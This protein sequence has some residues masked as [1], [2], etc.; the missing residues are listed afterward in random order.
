MIS[1]KTIAQIFETAK[2]E[3]VVGDFVNLKRRGVNM[4]GLC[5]FHDEKTPSFTVSPAKNICKCFGCGKGGSPV[6]FLMEHDNL[7]YPEA[8]RVLAKKYGIE[9][10]ED[11]NPDKSK[12]E[13]QHLESLYLINQFTKDFFIDQMN[14]TDIGRS[15]GLHYFKDR[16]FREDIIERFGLGYSPNDGKSLMKKLDDVGYE[17]TLYEKLGVVKNGRDFFRGRVMF[18]IHNLTGKCIGFGGRILKANKKAPK[19]VNS[20]EAEIYNKSKILYGMFFAKNAIRKKDECILVEGYTDT[21]SL[22]QAGIENV[23]ASSGTSLTIEQI[24]LIKRFTP[25]IK[26][27]YDGDAAGVKAALRGLDL[28]LE[29]DLNVKVVLLPE[30]EDPDSYAQA[31][32]TEAFV[33]YL[34]EKATDFILFKMNLLMEEAKGDPVKR[35]DLIK[36]IVSSISKIP[37]PIKRSVYVRE[38]AL[39][40][41]VGEKVLINAVNKNVVGNIQSRQRQQ[42]INERRAN[43]NAFE[44]AGFPEEDHSGNNDDEFGLPDSKSDNK[45]FESIG[46]QEKD[47]ARILINFGH[48]NFNDD[49]TIAQFIFT[50]IGEIMDAFKT[51]P[52]NSIVF[53]YLE[54]VKNK[55]SLSPQH[56]LNHSDQKIREVALNFNSSPYEYSPGWKERFNITTSQPEP[57]QNFISDTTQ[58]LMRFKLEKIKELCEENLERIK[59]IAGEKD[60]AKENRYMQVHIRLKKMEKELTDQLNTV[61]LKQ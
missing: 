29:Q 9:I 52:Y 26:I 20:S 39:Q 58:A 35:S 56:F 28:V 3:D 31:I 50:N 46:F 6:S 4:I 30:G 19:Y 57:D 48:Q 22:H 18:P 45:E 41:D 37:D 55:T 13:R 17:K 59:S 49:K 32:G 5:P 38:C 2:I 42:E 43:R 23:V 53:E 47:I 11:G 61:V 54:A 21:I 14:N 27:L 36:D 34:D 25:N 60:Q 40:L 24:R 44:E 16:G 10:E 15:V 8:L 1:Q 33:K 51:A 12:E 7:T